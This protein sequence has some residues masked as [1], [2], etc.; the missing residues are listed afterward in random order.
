MAGGRRRTKTGW[1]ERLRQLSPLLLFVLPSGPEPLEVELV[2]CD[3]VRTGALCEL[4]G[5][6]AHTLTVLRPPSDGDSLFAVVDG[7]PARL[8]PVAGGARSTL[9]V[10]AGARAL[11]LF[12]LGEDRL[13]RVDVGLGPL[14][15]E[16]P[17]RQAQAALAAGELE[18]AY[19][20]AE[21]IVLRGGSPGEVARARGVMARAAR[22]GAPS[23]KSPGELFEE[24]IAADRA[25]GL[26]RSG[27]RDHFAL[28]HWLRE[29]YRLDDA[30]RV[31]DDA[32]RLLDELGSDASLYAEAKAQLPYYQA[33]TALDRGDVLTAVAAAERSY[34]EATRLGLTSD[35]EAADTLRLELTPYLGRYDEARAIA[36]RLEASLP[37][38]EG[39]AR[40]ERSTNLGWFALRDGQRGGDAAP[41]AALALFQSAL[42]LTEKECDSALER[43]IAHT[44]LAR[45]LLA[46]RG[47]ALPPETLEEVAR[48]LDAART[49]AEPPWELRFEW[50]EL[51]GKLQLLR[52]R[53]VEAGLELER[54]RGWAEQGSHPAWRRKVLVLLARVA[55]RAGNAKGAEELLAESVRSL[56]EEA[57]LVPLGDGRGS[58]LASANEAP[59][60]LIELQLARGDVA[61]AANTAEAAL[62]RALRSVS[63]SAV[64]GRADPAFAAATE[65]YQAERRALDDAAKDD[66]LHGGTLPPDVAEQR[67]AL[68]ARLRA[69]ADKAL[70]LLPGASTPFALAP[71]AAGEA[72]L[73]YYRSAAGWLGF[74]THGE[75]ARYVRL[76][77]PAPLPESPEELAA[78]FL[79]PFESVLAGATALRIAA[80]DALREVELHALPLGGRPLAALG[81]RYSVGLS[82]KPGP[83]GA[84]APSA[85]V[86][87]V[88]D[89]RRNLPGAMVEAQAVGNLHGPQ[90][91]LLLQGS[92]TREN[93]LEEI[94][95]H[96]DLLHYVGHAAP[97]GTAGVPARDGITGALLLADDGQFL[98]TDVLALRAAP[99]LV[100]LSA[101][102]SANASE[103]FGLAQAFLAAGADA[104]I[105]TSRPIPDGAG[106]ALLLAL[107]DRLRAGAD[108]ATA[109]RDAQLSLL[110]S[111]PNARRFRLLVP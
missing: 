60:A 3:E 77:L 42:A 75:V 15:T 70:S 53:P 103:G 100:V 111:E 73:V 79:A 16:E 19:R 12:T 94:D 99:R 51:G 105:A 91:R 52:G 80:P 34:R 44:N 33:S 39:C 74:A 96:P 76:A 108:V 90:A 55:Q 50:L 58:F 28:S 31:L 8:Q 62:G 95:A 40:F 24:A 89:P 47:E 18:A 69:A 98:V 27:L 57:R 7:E 71:L 22:R 56:E 61:S 48:H 81:V 84:L 30:R 5:G 59:D 1:W 102:E 38:L 37:G 43:S 72:R 82:A 25:A 97:E 87:I 32:S 110:A 20:G 93:V 9:D 68:H 104:V 46:G 85:S 101:C 14:Q 83:T 13:A 78:L 4:D 88:G 6:T 66:W 49:L 17:L 26:V 106:K 92:A 36:Q 109:F 2:G 67:R 23:A 65:A 45:A 35:A 64:T 107:H 86:L 21:A 10:P 63:A 11:R 41:D 29:R 54:L